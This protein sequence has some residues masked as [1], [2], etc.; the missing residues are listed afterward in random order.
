MTKVFFRTQRKNFY[1]YALEMGKHLF[2]PF[3]TKIDYKHASFYCT[4]L[5]LLW[6]CNFY[7]LKVC[8][9]PAL[10]KS[11]GVIFQIAFVQFISLCHIFIIHAV[12]QAFSLLFIC[13]GDL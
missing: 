11:I 8:D 6:R 9:N 5:I 4:S 2:H 13:Y 1:F 10:S 12:V 3:Y 7:K